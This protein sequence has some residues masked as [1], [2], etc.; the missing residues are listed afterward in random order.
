MFINTKRILEDCPL[1]GASIRNEQ[2]SQYSNN[3]EHA[4]IMNTYRIELQGQI[5]IEEL[6][7]MSP[8]QMIPVEIT[9]KCTAFTISTDQSGM[10]GLLRHLHN[11]GLVI[12]SCGNWGTSRQETQKD[13]KLCDLCVR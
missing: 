4:F 11:L 13:E 5:P 9:P 8:V 3:H 1:P 10:L 2:T 7:A 12:V 6:N